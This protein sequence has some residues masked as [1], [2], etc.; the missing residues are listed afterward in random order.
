MVSHLKIYSVLQGIQL[1]SEINIANTELEIGGRDIL[2]TVK[3]LNS[4]TH[5]VKE[6]AREQISSGDIVDK[7]IMLLADIT[8]D[9]R[10]L[11]DV[12]TLGAQDI[13]DAMTFLNNLGEQ[14]K[15]SIG[16]FSEMLEHLQNN[17][18]NFN[19]TFNY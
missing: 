14:S 1:E 12:N 16:E 8:Q 13:S 17:F 15:I 6:N 3:H 18:D 19:Q 5:H 2:E 4:I 11:I 7:Q 10:K 9:V